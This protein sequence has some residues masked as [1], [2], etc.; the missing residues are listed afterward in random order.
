MDDSLIPGTL[1]VSKWSGTL[2]CRLKITVSGA[3]N[4]YADSFTFDHNELGIIV[5]T[6]EVKGLHTVGDINHY[7]HFVITSR[8]LG[9]TSHGILSPWK[10]A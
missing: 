6:R 7:A 5:S 10:K 8:S 4:D 1:I 2:T 9:W 3:W